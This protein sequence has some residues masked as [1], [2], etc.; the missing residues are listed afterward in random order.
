M[1]VVV[2]AGD[3]YDIWTG[4]PLEL[5]S[6]LFKLEKQAIVCQIA[7]HEY[8]VRL[9]PIDLVNYRIEDALDKKAADGQYLVVTLTIE[10][11]GNKT[12]TIQPNQLLLTNKT[13]NEAEKYTQEIEK[14][15]M[16]PFMREYGQENLDRLVETQP[17][18]VNPR[19][20]AERYMIFMVPE[21]ASLGSYNLLYK[22]YELELPLLSEATAV[23][24]RRNFE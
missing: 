5:V 8:G 18:T 6:C 23:D 15:M 9:E 17:I 10:N 2:V 11:T 16:I 4:E 21:K 20:K 7:C 24:D 22:P 19:V 1:P 3:D 12:E 14:S 13:E